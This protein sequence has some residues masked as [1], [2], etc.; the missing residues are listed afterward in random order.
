MPFVRTKK[1]A[2]SA[3]PA[4]QSP[5]GQDRL[6]RGLAALD[7]RQQDERLAPDRALTPTAV[8]Q[9]GRGAQA[10]GPAAAS[11]AGRGAEVLRAPLFADPHEETGPG[12]FAM[13]RWSSVPGATK[14]RLQ[15]HRSL[16]EFRDEPGY[17]SGTDGLNSDMSPY[18]GEW[19]R[20]VVW[21]V[22][23]IAVDAAGQAV[24]PWS[25]TGTVTCRPELAKDLSQGAAPSLQLYGG[26]TAW[27]GPGSAAVVLI[28]PDGDLA[29]GASF[30]ANRIQVGKDPGKFSDTVY[31]NVFADARELVYFY[32]SGD[33][34]SKLAPSRT[35][36]P[37]EPGVHYVR[38]RRENASSVSP[39]SEVV[40]VKVLA[41]EA[42]G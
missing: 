24:G 21:Y 37:T 41:P 4:A 27:M 7:L 5:K 12:A 17:G 8:P 19:D 9:L 3:R 18:E 6:G 38:L 23:V 22:R 2:E 42:S 16:S 31:D 36:H 1:E 13:L 29:R 25:P 14:Y 32:I 39:W 30:Y 10:Q 20:D 11:P 33:P 40:P 28:G 26:D 15:R 34:N 35:Y